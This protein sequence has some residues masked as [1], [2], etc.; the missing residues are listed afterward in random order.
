MPQ[1]EGLFKAFA[2]AD[3]SD[4]HLSANQTAKV[5]IN[6]DLVSISDNVL[7]EGQIEGILKE[8][9]SDEMWSNFNRTKSLLF[10]YEVNEIGRFRCKYLFDCNGPAAVFR[11]IPL[12]VIGMEELNLPD[13][14]RKI[15]EYSSGLVC[16][17]GK[18]GSG[19]STSVAAIIDYINKK[20]EK[21]ILT[22]ENPI[23]F[24]FS[25]SNS[26]ITQRE[27]DRD[28]NSFVNAVHSAM[29]SDA[30]IIYISS[31]EDND[32]AELAIKCAAL[33]YLV[34]VNVNACGS[35]NTVKSLIERFS[36]EKQPVISAMLAESLRAIITHALCK[37]SNGEM[38]GAYEILLWEDS[39]PN[40][41]R[42]KQYNNLKSIIDSNKGHGMCLLDSN[43]NQL[44]NEGVIAAK[45]AYRNSIDKKQF[46]KHMQD[47]E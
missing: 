36:D 19:R 43:L 29:F 24:K 32:T 7:N 20:Y 13:S 25:N 14:L 42:N 44:L 12:T 15:S 33:G 5:R 27:V 45:E 3:A 18:A 31:I 26:I 8:I 1:I 35:I 22:I 34:F 6:G 30:D 4:L 11:K 28:S 40:S 46:L 17:S 16:F 23:E 9:C 10:A 2:E 41:I 39:L 38:I 37:S 21:N 47:E